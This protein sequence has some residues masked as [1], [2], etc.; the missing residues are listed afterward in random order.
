[1]ACCFVIVY[2]EVDVSRQHIAHT[3]KGRYD[4]QSSTTQL[5]E[6]QTPHAIKSISYD[7]GLIMRVDPF[8]KNTFRSNDNFHYSESEMQSNSP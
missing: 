3:F 8:F 7:L 1:M 6:P 2:S 5:Q 4:I